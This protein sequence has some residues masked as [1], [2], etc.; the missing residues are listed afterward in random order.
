MHLKFTCGLLVF[1]SE[2][3][4]YDFVDQ[5]LNCF[6]VLILVGCRKSRPN[7]LPSVTKVRDTNYYARVLVILPGVTKARVNEVGP[8]HF[9][10]IFIIFCVIILDCKV[11]IVLKSHV[12]C[13][14]D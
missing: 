8:Q 1:T 11:V 12:Q 13:K 5:S 9:S 6:E 4:A 10:S 2:L 14:K 3:I 7:G